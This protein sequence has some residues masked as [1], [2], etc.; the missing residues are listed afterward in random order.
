M[1][2]FFDRARTYRAIAQATTANIHDVQRAIEASG[3]RERYEQDPT[4][5][6]SALGFLEELRVV[7][8]DAAIGPVPDLTILRDAWCALF[9]ENK[10]VH[11]VIR[12]LKVVEQIPLILLSD[13]NELH[14]NHFRT[15]YQAMHEMFDAV[16]LSF[17]VGVS[18]ERNAPAMLRLAVREAGKK[19]ILYVDDRQ[20]FVDAATGIGI[21]AHAYGS[22]RDLIDWLRARELTIPLTV[23]D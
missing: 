7:L 3:I 10:V 13:T 17:R 14:Y 12:H 15:R 19:N 1:L 21:D 5:F 6:P 4:A 23:C 18:K 11:K 16:I 20:S 9:W 22:D 2:L 8:V